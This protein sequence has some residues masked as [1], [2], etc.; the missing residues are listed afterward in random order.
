MIIGVRAASVRM[1]STSSTTAYALRLSGMPVSS[2]NRPRVWTLTSR[3]GA[4]KSRTSADCSSE[5][6]DLAGEGERLGQQV[7]ER[8]AVG[9][10]LAER[11]EALAQ[12]LVGFELELGLEGVDAGDAL[13]VGA[14]LL[15]LA[16]KQGTVKEAHGGQPSNG[17]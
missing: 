6:A 14:K 12:L 5:L 8:L 9:R 2:S 4:M 13:L 7:V 16:G 1:L 17:S 10:A 3:T 15:G 11:V